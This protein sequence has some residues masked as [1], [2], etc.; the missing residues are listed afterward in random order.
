M[1]HCGSGVAAAAYAAG[2][3]SCRGAMDRGG[4][5]GGDGFV[6]IARLDPA[7]S[8]EIPVLVAHER[9]AADENSDGQQEGQEDRFHEG[10]GMGTGAAVYNMPLPFPARKLVSRIVRAE[11]GVFW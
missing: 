7:F 10:G 3:S 1:S 11:S 2:A 9:A 6:E 4:M 5:R 8:V